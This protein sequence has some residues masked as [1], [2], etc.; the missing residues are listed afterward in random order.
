MT[1]IAASY[2]SNGGGAN[3]LAR[4]AA[5]DGALTHGFQVGFT[6][7]AGVAVF[8]AVIAAALLRPH[9]EGAEI[10]PLTSP[11]I[12]ELEEAA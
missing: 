10:E 8:G 12:A 4:V 3:G 6:V 2:A 5:V 1:T 7:L 11:S 9:A